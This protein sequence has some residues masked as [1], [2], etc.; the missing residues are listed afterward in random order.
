MPQKNLK[1]LTDLIVQIL[2]FL[3][4]SK[5]K[6]NKINKKY[7]NVYTTRYITLEG[8]KLWIFG[9][10]F[11]CFFQIRFCIHGL[12]FFLRAVGSNCGISDEHLGSKSNKYVNF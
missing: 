8:S 12:F 3:Y 7:K 11:P 1:Y 4:H 10:K 5:G 2:L 9:T 6:I